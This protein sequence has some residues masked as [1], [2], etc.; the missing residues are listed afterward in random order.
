MKQYGLF[1]QLKLDYNYKNIFIAYTTNRML[2]KH[3][4][5]FLEQEKLKYEI[6]IIFS[7]LFQFIKIINVIPL[8][9]CFT[10]DSFVNYYIF[11]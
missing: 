9:I 7:Y 6:H 8:L 2:A 3:N 4:Y 1:N 11:D 5:F 10:T